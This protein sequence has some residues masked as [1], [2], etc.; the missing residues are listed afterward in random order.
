M[1]GNEQPTAAAVFINSVYNINGTNLLRHLRTPWR[2]L[3][4]R[5]F[6]TCIMM[7]GWERPYLATDNSPLVPVV[8]TRY[9]IFG[10]F[11]GYSTV[12]Y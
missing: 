11:S 10:V 3:C 2:A 4:K 9:N 12:I 6:N 7:N 1:R 8:Y 5:I